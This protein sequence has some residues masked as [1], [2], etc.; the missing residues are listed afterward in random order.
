M[1]QYG[2]NQLQLI[3]GTVHQNVSITWVKIYAGQRAIFYGDTCIFD[4][5]FVHIKHAWIS[6]GI[7]QFYEK[8]AVNPVKNID[9]S[10][11][12]K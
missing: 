4:I 5:Y 10:F 8:W 12:H 9:I 1:S 7:L 6:I 11:P 3:Y 2:L